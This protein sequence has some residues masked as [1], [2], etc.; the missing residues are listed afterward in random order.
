MHIVGGDVLFGEVEATGV[1]HV[2]EEGADEVFVALHWILLEGRVG[3]VTSK[4]S[5]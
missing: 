3:G 5:V 1:E 4:G 2:V